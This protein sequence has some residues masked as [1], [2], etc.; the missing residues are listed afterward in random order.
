M[1]ILAVT[2]KTPQ[3]DQSSGDL[4]FFTLLS[5]LARQCD[6]HL[7]AYSDKPNDGSAAARAALQLRGV[8]VRED[9]LTA[10][11]ADASLDVVLA[12]F[13]SVALLVEPAVRAWKPSARLVVDSV[14]V[15]FHRMRSKA[16]LT[17]ADMDCASAEEVQREE[18]SA[19][20]HSD[21]V[22]TV[23]RSD[24]QILEAE[25]MTTE[26]FVI[27]NI[28]I[29]HDAPPRTR[30]PR[31]ELIF[32]GGY[33]HAPNI[34]AIVFFCEEILP[35]VRQKI[36]SLRLRVIGSKPTKQVL[37]LQAADI[38]V[39]GYVADTT[40]YL[41]SS[42]ISV[43]PLRY[44]GG[45]KG[46]I[47]EALAHGVPVVTTAVGAEGFGFKSGIELIIADGPEAFADAI[48]ALWQDPALFEKMRMDGWRAI[49]EKYSVSSV[50][51]LLPALLNR[52]ETLS[53]KRKSL[54]QRLKVKTRYYAQQHLKIGRS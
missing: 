49:N 51:H 30:T 9:S 33:N 46:K 11:L 32:I 47:G 22:V 3:P 54:F 24:S 48:V 25:G 1:K 13:Y 35:L 40:P 15:H 23:S 20:Q 19:Y 53:A 50:E 10:C 28:H 6:V 7:C 21:L 36:P 42:D 2:W 12:E 8:K 29:M 26:T 37:D 31:L 5:L 18:M 41:L 17:G 38:E 44:G 34:D 45:I 52:M 14:D 4:R 27:P 43:A 39:L 16:Q